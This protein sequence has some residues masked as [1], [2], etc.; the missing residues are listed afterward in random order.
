[1]EFTEV[2]NGWVGLQKNFISS[3]YGNQVFTELKNSLDWEQ[4][5]IVLFGRK[6][7]IP[8]M[9][10]FHSMNGQGYGYSGKPLKISPFNELLLDLKARIEFVSNHSFN[11]VLINLYRN[12]LDSNGWHSDN[13]KELGLNPVI[14]SLS[15]GTSRIFQLKHILSKERIQFELSHGDLLL[16][17][18]E[19]QHFWKHQVPK[20]PKIK[21]ARINLTF[22]KIDTFP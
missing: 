4:G 12:G 9:E 19:L 20:Q 13:E 2:Q 16:M 11:S 17:G 7:L 5:N 14:A 10:S 21:E 8:R 1:M 6:L 15:V 3:E 22:R 18:G